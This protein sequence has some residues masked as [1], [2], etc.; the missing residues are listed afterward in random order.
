MVR[1]GEDVPKGQVLRRF[2]SVLLC[3]VMHLGGHTREIHHLTRIPL[4]EGDL[5]K[6]RSGVPPC[7]ALPS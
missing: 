3:T 7:A 1:A 5:T 6:T 4:G 2:E